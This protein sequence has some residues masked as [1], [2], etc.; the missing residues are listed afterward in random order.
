MLVLET[1]YQLI[2]RLSKSHHTCTSNRLRDCSLLK[3]GERSK[4]ER[5]HVTA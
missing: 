1:P 4:T 5:V 2:V 3:P